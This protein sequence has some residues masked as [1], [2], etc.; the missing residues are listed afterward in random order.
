MIAFLTLFLGIATGVHT[1]AL[2][3]SAEVARIELY[4]DGTRTVVP[5]PPWTT[6]IDLGGE[7]APRELVAVAF[8]GKG[9]RLGE[10][11]Q[12]V[13]RA[14]SDAEAAFALERD[15]AGR[16]VAAR[17]VWRC[18][19]SPDPL[20]ISVTFDG[21]PLEATN[22]DRIPIP[23]H[24]AGAHHVLLAD[25]TFAGRIT[26]TAVTSFGGEKTDDTLRE[27]SA[28]AVRVSPGARL[29]KAERMEGWF[30][31]EGRPLAVAAVEEG[32]AEVVFVL[33]GRIRQDLERLSAEDYF[34][35]PWPR[36][37]PL[38]LADGNRFLFMHTNP[39]VIAE[40]RTVTRV[41]PVSSMYTP[42][43]GS[44]LRL[45]QTAILN[46][47]PTPPQ[48]SDS[49]A[50]AGLAATRRE[51]RRAVV[52]LL[53]AEASDTGDLDAA[54]ARRYLA[55]LRVP[56]HVWRLSPVESRAAGDWPGTVDASTIDGLGRAF[57]VLRDDLST[58]RIVW[59][60]GRL[61]PS[62]VEVTPKAAGI[63][64]AR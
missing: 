25:L 26:A 55:R 61:L 10:A 32:P 59:V 39:Q 60:E 56:L 20:A 8:D 37:R 4:V 17:L 22:P 5:G 28:V 6:T 11:K 16:V 44:F 47:L 34:P 30:A 52:L 1:V 36:P 2:S 57:E 45:A 29:P 27:L 38:K 7:I 19:S 40:A 43:D 23:S 33:S 9:A 51:R 58:Q 24:S 41:F 63:L 54:R 49:V 31:S 50:T 21:R 46:E 48:I 3:A 18:P 13:N 42:E 62:A 53:G 15:R 12:W 35:W 14:T 64:A